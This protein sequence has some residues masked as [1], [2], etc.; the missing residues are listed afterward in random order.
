[1]C[2]G[3]I[4]PKLLMRDAGDRYRATAVAPTTQPSRE[5]PPELMGGLHGV[6]ARIALRFERSKPLHPAE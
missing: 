4:D 1:M 6:W 2:H 5:L 3:S